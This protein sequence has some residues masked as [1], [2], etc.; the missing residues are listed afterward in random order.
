MTAKKFFRSISFKCIVVLLAIVLFSGIF[1]TFFNDLFEVT[2]EERFQRALSKIYGKSVT[3]EEIDL[4]D[5]TTEFSTATVNSAYYVTDDGNYL[6]NVSGKN[7]YGGDVTCWIVVKMNGTSSIAGVGNVVIDTAPGESYI[8]RI[9]SAYLEKFSEIEYSDG[10]VYELGFANGSDQ[11]GSDY[12]AT[13]ASR[14]MRAISNSVNGAISFVKAYAL[15]MD[16]EEP[17]ETVYDDFAY[18]D[19]IN[20]E[21]TSHSVADGSVSYDIT[22][23][24]RG[25]AG[26]FE[27]TIVVG[28]DKTV[29][30]FTID[31]NGSTYNYDS[32]MAD[33]KTLI[34]GRNAEQLAA[35]LDLENNKV[36]SS[37]L[38][39]GASY[40]NFLCVYAA[41][42][43]T[44]NYNI[45]LLLAGGNTQ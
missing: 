42:F 6:L 1:L 3:T 20:K 4:T 16:V 33:V 24:S 35:M 32:N 25:E 45:A 34:E 27:L 39:T 14:S 44:S 26:A 40:S 19:Y 22:T 5:E 31:R 30:S 28:A 29:S 38:T 41:L 2:D 11:K 18:T 21:A 9:T 8:S 7:G 23:N 10:K 17:V 12:I 13:G 43:A 36:S 37:D 15:G